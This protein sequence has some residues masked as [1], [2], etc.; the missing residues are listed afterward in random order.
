MN[1]WTIEQLYK[2]TNGQTNRWTRIKKPIFWKRFVYFKGFLTGGGW[3]SSLNIKGVII[4]F[5]RAIKI[6][7][8]QGSLLLLFFPSPSCEIKNVLLEFFFIVNGRAPWM[9][10][11][12][13][14][15]TL[16]SFLKQCNSSVKTHAVM[17]KKY[18]F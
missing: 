6:Q 11:L 12:K 1:E 7:L 13:P 8:I 4:G 10:W 14:N 9:S 18:R 5:L 3:V 17:L 16:I 2:L 15:Q